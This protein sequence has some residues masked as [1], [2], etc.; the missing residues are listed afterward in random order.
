MHSAGSGTRA[1]QQAEEGVMA[2]IQ[3]RKENEQDV[4]KWLKDFLVN[5]NIALN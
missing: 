1:Q 2:N 3:W 4:A 5:K